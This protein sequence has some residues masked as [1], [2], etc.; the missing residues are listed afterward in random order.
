MCILNNIALRIEHLSYTYPDGRQALRDVSLE[1]LNGESVAITGPNGAGKSTLAM[2]FNGLLIGDGSV[3]VCGT[4]VGK[5]TLRDVRRRVG[6][7]FQDPD[8]QLFMPTVFDD[9]AFGPLNM[10]CEADEVRARVQRALERVCLEQFDQ[11]A[12]H[13]LSGGEKRA[14]SIA[15]VLSMDPEVLVLDEPTSTLDARGRRGLMTFLRHVD[16]TRIVITHDLEFV[17]EVCDRC[18][19]MDDGRIVADGSCTEILADEPLLEAHG[20]EVPISLRLGQP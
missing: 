18:I 1:I 7:V 8:D 6:F 20:L 10:G 3:T 15:T 12:P 13:H 19:L 11:R 5:N 16:A 14:A 4:P 17:L 2:H 9:V